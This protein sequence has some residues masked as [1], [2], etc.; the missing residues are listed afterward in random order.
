MQLGVL[1]NTDRLERSGFLT[2]AQ[3]IDE[4]G[5]ESLWLPELFTRDPFT[6]SAYILA[7]TKQ[8]SLATGI[9]NLYG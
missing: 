4:L 1:F 5:F 7:N 2:Y 9:A 8:V 3:R 6:A